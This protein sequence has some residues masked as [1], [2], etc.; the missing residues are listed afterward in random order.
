M[1]QELL[2]QFLGLL[3]A[4]SS[5]KLLDPEQQA[6]IKANYQNATDDQLRQGIQ[7]LQED[8]VAT[9]KLADERKKNQEELEKSVNKIKTRLREIKREE[10]REE[11]AADEAADKEKEQELLQEIESMDKPKEKVPQKKKKFLGIF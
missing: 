8:K 2:S 5:F 11:E 3:E 10:L 6:T 4:S 7:A 9:T 1:N